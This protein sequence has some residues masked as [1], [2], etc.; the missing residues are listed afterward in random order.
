M[1]LLANEFAGRG[2]G[3]GR[4]S[5]RGRQ[6][7]CSGN[8]ATGRCRM[9]AKVLPE[10]WLVTLAWREKIDQMARQLYTLKA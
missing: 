9:G 7:R 6:Y 1:V 2:T 4:K 3:V 8:G 10:R 5:R